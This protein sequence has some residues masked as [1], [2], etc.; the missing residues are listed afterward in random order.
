MSGADWRA[1]SLLGPLTNTG[2]GAEQIARAALKQ[3][4]DKLDDACEAVE[5]LW[6]SRDQDW[7]NVV[8]TAFVPTK[9]NKPQ[10]SSFYLGAQPSLIVGEPARFDKWPA[11]TVRCGNRKASEDLAQL[12]QADVW[13]IELIVEVLTIAG[14]FLQDPLDD[15]G[16]SDAIDR[17][18][19]R[20]SDAVVACIDADRS[21]GANVLPLQRPA[22]I[23]PSLPFVMKTNKGAGNYLLHQ[24]AELVWIATAMS[25]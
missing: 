18:Y 17:Q 14:P 24:G 5:N 4:M 12:D 19:Q 11:I 22:T 16:T 8:G 21:L 20:L 10:P 1:G 7:S 23:T 2:T 6:Y 3:I 25:L 9:I 15:R 13:D